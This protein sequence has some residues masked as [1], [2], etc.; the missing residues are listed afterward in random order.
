MLMLSVTTYGCGV[1]VSMDSCRS[2]PAG[3][4]NVFAAV[5]REAILS[6]PFSV[7]CHAAPPCYGE[8]GA[9]TIN[10]CY[11]DPKPVTTFW[12]SNFQPGPQMP[13]VNAEP[14]E[15]SDSK[16]RVYG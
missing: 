9:D 3:T 7:G 8:D 10:S 11:Y 14:K 2:L 5:V 16:F 15:S 12:P 1:R 13:T 6:F 4:P